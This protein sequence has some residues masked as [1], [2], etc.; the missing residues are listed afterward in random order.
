MN[1]IPANYNTLIPIFSLSINYKESMKRHYLEIEICYIKSHFL[2]RTIQKYR[3]IV[4]AAI[5]IWRQSKKGR[6]DSI[7]FS[8]WVFT[9][10]VTCD[11][12]FTF[13]MKYWNEVW[14][15]LSNSMELSPHSSLKLGLFY[16]SDSFDLRRTNVFHSNK[17]SF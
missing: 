11:D 12:C 13:Y 15:K 6:E 1:P 16:E 17:Q 10:L 7:D 9:W 5:E 3:K 2:L 8:I 14:F 4:Y